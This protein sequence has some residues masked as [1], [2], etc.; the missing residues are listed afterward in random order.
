MGI[1]VKK[2]DHQNVYQGTRGEEK[3]QYDDIY[4][5]ITSS[6]TTYLFDH[7]D[8]KYVMVHKMS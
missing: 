4:G 8:Y 6:G 3:H 7:E 2:G 1:N 5:S